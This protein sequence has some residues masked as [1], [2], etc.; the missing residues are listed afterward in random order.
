MSS[1][2]VQEG[3]FCTKY[4]G[5]HSFFNTATGPYLFAFVGNPAR[6]PDSC[7]YLNKIASPN[8]DVGVDGAINIMAREIAETMTNP[9]HNAWFDLIGYENADKW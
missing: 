9:Y 7:L 5:Y 1:R 6:C 4:C 8:L 2:D 3:A